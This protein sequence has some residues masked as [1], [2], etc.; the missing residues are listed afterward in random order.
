MNYELSSKTVGFVKNF[1]CLQ[2]FSQM[3][4]KGHWVWVLQELIILSVCVYF[5]I[6]IKFIYVYKFQ[7]KLFDCNK[8]IGCKI[9]NYI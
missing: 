2:H 3:K 8:I 6:Y 7:L 4:V 5:Y 1:I 9:G